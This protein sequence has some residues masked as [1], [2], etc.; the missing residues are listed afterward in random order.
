MKTIKLIGLKVLVFL[1]IVKYKKIKRPSYYYS[2]S[3][4]GH[5]KTFRNYIKCRDYLRWAQDLGYKPIITPKAQ[6]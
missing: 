5:A 1:G 3:I 2:V 6:K 4:N